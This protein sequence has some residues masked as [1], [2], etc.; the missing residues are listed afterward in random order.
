MKFGRHSS[1]IRFLRFFKSKK[2]DFFTFYCLASHVFSN[3]AG[4]AKKRPKFGA[5]FDNFRFDREYLRNDSRYPK[6]EKNM[7]DSDS[8]R[9]PRKKSGELWSTNKKVYWLT[10]SHPRAFLGGDYILALR[11]CCPLKFLYALEI[12]HVLIAHTRMGMGSPKKL[13]IVNF[14]IWLKIQR[15]RPYNFGDSGNILSK[16][17]RPRDELWSTNEKVIARILIYPNCSYILSSSRK[18]I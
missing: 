7:I 18:S 4:R 8:F 6:S 5:I 9:V 1:R 17:C 11:G 16:L 3:Y 13:L 15:V 12:D 10:L 2:R 14:K